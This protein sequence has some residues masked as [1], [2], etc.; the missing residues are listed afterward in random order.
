M[1]FHPKEQEYEP[2]DPRH[3]T[4][5][6]RV[7]RMLGAATNP[8]VNVYRVM[9]DPGARTAWHI[10]SGAQLLAILEG[11]CVLLTL[12]KGFQIITTGGVAVIPAGEKHWH[13]ALPLT[14]MTHLAIN[15]NATTKWLELVSD[16]D[17]DSSCSKFFAGS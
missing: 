15:V 3:F 12:S 13:G 5:N 17:Y 10:H 7:A 4:G 2:A 11:E 8:E 9:F 14:P 16:K 6:A 1:I